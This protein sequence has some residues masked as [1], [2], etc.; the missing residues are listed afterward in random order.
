MRKKLSLMLLLMSCIMLFSS[1]Q[2]DEEKIIGTWKM[3]LNSSVRIDDGM[4]LSAIGYNQWK[5]TFA[6][7]GLYSESVTYQGQLRSYYG[8]WAIVGDQLIVDDGQYSIADLTNRKLLLNDSWGHLVF[9]K[10]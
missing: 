3:D 9:I 7:N 8:I 1:C 4:T 2:K 6:E 10:E 5:L